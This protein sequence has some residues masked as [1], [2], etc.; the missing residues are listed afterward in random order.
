MLGSAE[1]ADFLWVVVLS[2]LVV[3]PSSPLRRDVDQAVPVLKTV[4][5]V[6]QCLSVVHR[7]SVTSACFLSPAAVPLTAG[8][9]LLA[10]LTVFHLL[11]RLP[12]PGPR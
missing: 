10:V 1:E 2:L 8:I 9:P 12:H 5:L 3:P 4:A 6:C 7:P 11:L